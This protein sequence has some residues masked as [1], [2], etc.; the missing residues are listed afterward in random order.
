M[1][2]TRRR[3]RANCRLL[4]FPRPARWYNPKALRRC[5]F[6]QSSPVP[7]RSAS[8]EELVASVHLHKRGPDARTEAHVDGMREV[9]HEGNGYGRRPDT[10]SS[11]V[12]RFFARDIPRPLVLAETDES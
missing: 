3:L 5:L 11:R 8:V 2:G 6:V 7:R 1:I 10:E 9:L 12:R 4:Y